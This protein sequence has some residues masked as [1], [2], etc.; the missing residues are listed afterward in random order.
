MKYL[1]FLLLFLFS[2]TVTDT[3][4]QIFKR[5]QREAER[6]LM[7][8]VE[9][10]VVEEVSNA[11]VR[12][13]YKPIDR[14]FD[15][16]VKDYYAK[17]TLEN[18]EIDWDKVN[19]RYDGMVD[20]FDASDRLPESYTFD[21]YMDIK[22]TD[23]EGKESESTMYYSKEHDYFAMQQN[24]DKT[25]MFI[26]FDGDNNLVGMF[27][28][29]KGRKTVQ[30]VPNMMMGSGTM[31]SP[32]DV[33]GEYD[34]FKLEKTGNTKDILGYRT[35]E[36][37]GE[38]EDEDILGYVAPKFPIQWQ[39]TFGGFVQQYTPETY[40]STV[41]ELKGMILYSENTLKKDKKKKSIWEVTKVYEENYVLNV[42]DYEKRR[43]NEE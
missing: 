23:Y 18:G 37:E 9:D 43:I 3:N 35:D 2:L 32:T 42:N 33:E 36:Y 16:M 1:P 6:K 13:A 24:E 28:E 5:I 31:I 27:K 25:M 20:A 29:E 12:A 10:R 4:A 17:D 8:K 40:S 22:M 34:D 11:I 19:A 38:T 30:A 41:L 26:L 14:A 21:L 7:K 39:E 15:N